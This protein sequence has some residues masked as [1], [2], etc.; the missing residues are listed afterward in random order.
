MHIK[1]ISHFVN[2]TSI[3]FP[4]FV[5]PSLIKASERHFLFEQIVV[6]GIP[7]Y[8]NKKEL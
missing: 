8:S 4:P 7:E 3:N 6:H 2:K 5:S 1:I